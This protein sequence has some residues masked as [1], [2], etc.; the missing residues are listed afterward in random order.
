VRTGAGIGILHDYI[1]RPVPELA[2]I[3]PDISIRRAYWTST[4]ESLR[5][6]TRIRTVIAFLQEVVGET[7][8]VFV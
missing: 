3:L 2:R 4:H 7:R 6:L 5:D 1:A 8:H